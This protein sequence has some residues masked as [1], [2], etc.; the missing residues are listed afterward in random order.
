MSEIF[1]KPITPRKPIV[2]ASLQQV[3]SLLRDYAA[4]VVNTMQ[5]YPTARTSYVRTG[6][7][8]RSWTFE[9]PKMR[10]ADLI[11]Q[12]GTNVT[13]APFVQGYKSHDPRQRALFSQYGWASVEDVLLR[14]WG[15]YRPLIQRALS[16]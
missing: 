11:V 16:H 8:G 2:T 3:H 14:E 4:K 12:A 10:G 5:D 15:S 9:G 13:Y 6:R 1:F 7:L